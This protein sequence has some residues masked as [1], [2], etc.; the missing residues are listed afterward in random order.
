LETLFYSWE[1][2]LPY[3]TNRNV[4]EDALKRAIKELNKDDSIEVELAIDRDRKDIPGSVDIA[5]AILDKVAKAAVFVGDISIINEDQLRAANA[6][7][8]EKGEDKKKPRATPNPN[9]L[10]ELGYAIGT[11]GWKRSLMVMN[12]AYG[13]LTDDQKVEPRSILPFDL[14]YR[15]IVTYNYRGAT[16]EDRSALIKILTAKLKAELKGILEHLAAEPRIVEFPR[17]KINLTGSFTNTTHCGAQFLCPSAT[18]LNIRIGTRNDNGNEIQLLKFPSLIQNK[19]YGCD[20][21]SGGALP[22]KPLIV[23]GE[24]STEDDRLFRVERTMHWDNNQTGPRMEEMQRYFV[25]DGNG[26]WKPIAT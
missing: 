11:L 16:D 10:V 15:S 26:K 6:G 20:V 5:N 13:G 23:F 1:S 9:V 25:R 19:P 18:L 8:S 24:Y 12:T 4:I 2:D 21:P 7:S 17:L 14:G 3:S 22:I